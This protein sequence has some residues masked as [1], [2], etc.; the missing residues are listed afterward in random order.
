M[1][2]RRDFD[3]LALTLGG[4]NVRKKLTTTK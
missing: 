3:N 4:D 2:N 1:I